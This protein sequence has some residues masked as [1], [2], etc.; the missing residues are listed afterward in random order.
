RMAAGEQLARPGDVLLDA[1]TVAALGPGATLGPACVDPATGE[2][3]A[4]LLA[5]DAP[6]APA[7]W[8]PVELPAATLRPWVLP[9]VWERHQAGLGAFLTELRPAVALFL[10]FGGLDFDDEAAAGWL[11]ALIRRVQAICAELGGTLL[12][13]TL[14]DKGA[15]LYASFGALVAHEDDARRAAHAALALHAAAAE[16]GLSGI[17]IGLSQ[18]TLRCGASGGPTRQTYAALG[19]EVNLAVRLMSRAA[20]GETLLSGR[21]QR[22][23]GEAF[24]L[25]PRPPI[26]L[27]GKAEPLPVFALTGIAGRR[28]VR[29]QEPAYALPMVGRTRELAAIQACLERAQAGEGQ[30][31]VIQAE[32]GM[33]KS[34]L[35]AEAV[36]LARR[37]G[38]VG[39]DG[40]AAA[41]ERQTPYLA[42][43]PV[44]QALLDIDPDA[45]ARRLLRQLA[46]ELEERVPERVAALPLLDL[47]LEREL[48]ETAFTQTLTSQER[49]GMRE[50][51]LLD[52]LV[53]AAREAGA[54]GSALLLVLEDT[55]W[56]DPLGRDL[57][58]R[59]AQ[60]AA[61]LPLLLV[62]ATRPA[63]PQA[64]DPLAALPHTTTLTLEGLDDGALEGL[65]RAKL[66]QLYPARTAAL[67]LGLVA[68]L[69]ARAQGNPFCIEE[70]LSY[71][72]DRGITPDAPGALAGL[73]LP[74]SLQRLVLARIDQ[75]SERERA[76]L[77]VA[78]VVGRLFRAAWLPGFAPDLGDL[79]R[80]KADLERLARLD[81]TALDTPEPELTYLFKHVV[82]Q[83]VAYGGLPQALRARLHGAL[84]AWLE[85]AT[86]D[87]PPLDLLAYHYDH[88]DNLPRRRAYLRRAG[89]AAAADYANAA[90]IDYLSRALALTP[91]EDEQQRWALLWAREQVYALVG[92]RG[93]QVAD[94]EA[95]ATLAAR[96]G[97]R[98]RQAAVALRWSW[99]YET[100]TA[101]PAMI[102]AAQQALALAEG[103]MAQQALARL[104]WG[105]ALWR[106]GEFAEAQVQIELSLELARATGNHQIEMTALRLLGV[107][108]HEQN[109][110]ARA[111]AFYEQA[112]ALARA[113]HHR[114]GEANALGNLGLLNLTE[115]NYPAAREQITQ[116]VAISRISGDRRFEAHWLVGLGDVERRQG[117]YAT[118]RRLFEEALATFRA[119]DD[120]LFAAEAIINL[121]CLT[122]AEGDP[123]AARTRYEQALV[124][125][126]AVGDRTYQW[127]ALS[128]LGHTLVELGLAPQAVEAAQE[129]VALCDAL[130]DLVGGAAGRAGLARA[131]RAQQDLPGALAQ[132]E[133]VLRH[134]ETGTLNVVYGEP[135]RAYLPCYEVLR[136]AGDPRAGPLLA[137]AHAELQRM[138]ARLT[139][140]ERRVFREAVPW[141]R[142][143]VAAWAAHQRGAH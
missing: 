60:A 137:Q 93:P 84:A 109:H 72:H 4:R 24:A 21:V 2:R 107:V 127:W 91:E 10:R 105:T 113:I 71:L 36:R 125:F 88:S 134:L 8:E 58:L 121:G 67:P 103:D 126:R 63:L 112:L 119:I 87:A 138:A 132:V 77:R 61:D 118:A 73:E 129:A 128:E 16:L 66:A 18:G 14:G 108:A 15:F 70:L 64:P 115:G 56:L 17:Q 111:R 33:G 35:I 59:L 124:I 49:K 98:A 102:E 11:D 37:A 89:E 40:A 38:C 82:T 139:E 42:W 79:P 140:D 106:Q 95:L 12:Q 135:L 142:A 29:L 54:E 1:P 65:V 120:R 45:P 80:V 116:A 75:L 83:E 6:P 25:E 5:L 141:N 48:P 34:R 22:A 32:A 97:D 44:V 23:L 85:A 39:Y 117:A 81:L 26:P 50:A 31:V 53:Q 55:H 101:Y 100:T 52:L 30:V 47:L 19:D 20:P 9:L 96:Q 41:S 131:L 62:V 46:G 104:H 110:F 136:D 94:L 69:A 133:L 74:D 143:I 122:A 3:F 76:T 130:G 123:A 90:A 92:E 28:A 57:L 78:S 99:Y 27:K 68:T 43:R 7:P 114:V 51:L 86:P 13:L